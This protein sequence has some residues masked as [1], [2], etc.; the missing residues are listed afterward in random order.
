MLFVFDLKK[1]AWEKVLEKKQQI[2]P[3]IYQSLIILSISISHVSNIWEKTTDCL[4]PVTWQKNE[5]FN[6]NVK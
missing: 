4:S 1:K 2:I 5:N 6:E 3:F